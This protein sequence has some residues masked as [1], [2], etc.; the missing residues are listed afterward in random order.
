MNNDLRAG[1]DRASLHAELDRLL[2]DVENI[3][4]PQN[5]PNAR[6]QWARVIM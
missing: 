3:F 4:A 5:D 6:E 1:R 2:D